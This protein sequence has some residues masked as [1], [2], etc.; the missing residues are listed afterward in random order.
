M[1]LIKF[2]N[3]ARG[4]T[5]L[6]SLIVVVI[7]GVLLAIAVPSISDW[8]I[9]QR[10]KASAAE[11]VADI[12][13]SRGEAV[14]RNVRVGLSFQSVANNQSCYTA[15]TKYLSL[16]CNC[17]QG[18]RESCNQ[19]FGVIDDFSNTTEELKTV[20]LPASSKVTM[21]ASRD[22]FF[23]APNGLMEVKSVAQVDFNGQNSRLLRVV[24]NALG[25]PLI[26]APSGSRISGYVACG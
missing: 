22:L 10:V 16:T 7:L 11:L 26:C 19:S 14:K 8:I 23:L 18:A 4:F 9:I 3:S 21:I 6:E 5:L 20:T 2:P 1:K 12:K 17:L 13:F 15:H 24:V 25:R